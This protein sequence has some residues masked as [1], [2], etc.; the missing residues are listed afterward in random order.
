M[1]G[2]GRAGGPL[3]CAGHG[4]CRLSVD[5]RVEREGRSG[6]VFRVVAVVGDTAE[7]FGRLVGVVLVLFELLD[8]GLPRE[9]R[10][11]VGEAGD[12]VFVEWVDRI[13]SEGGIRG[14]G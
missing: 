6:R 14:G 8:D 11:E 5:G 12:G 4:G 3:G 9:G 1:G 7:G 2:R 13:D 10:E